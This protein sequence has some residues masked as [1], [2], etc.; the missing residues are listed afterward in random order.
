MEQQTDFKNAYSLIEAAKTIAIASH[1]RPDGDAI[2]STLALHY[3]LGFFGKTSHMYIDG[4]I[5][6]NFSY[7]E[8]TSKIRDDEWSADEIPSYDLLIIV[9]ANSADRLGRFKKL[10]E[11][12]KK[13]LVFDHHLDPNIDA[14][15]IV[16]NTSRASTGEVLFE[17]FKAFN[18][19]INK[20]MAA[21]LYTAIS[22]DTGCFVFPS[23]TAYTHK[24]AAE[25]LSIGIDFATINYYNFRMFDRS[26]LDAFVTALDSIE[27]LDEGKIS[28][29]HI[30]HKMM[31]RYNFDHD[32][33]H[34]IQRYAIDASGVVINLFFTEIDPD[35]FSVSLRSHGEVNVA[36]LAK[37]FGGGGHKN[38]AGFT[39]EGKYKV[40]LKSV[41]D[42]ARAII[43]PNRESE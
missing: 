25:L 9:D 43:P 34:R 36:E 10:V 16:M 14:D 15:T 5:S 18:I 31:S 2:G 11:T 28:L 19:P 26:K 7:M 13:I 20:S 21:A 12:S 35:V 23:T 8:G 29:V 42:E 22:T 30:N 6:Q 27:F 1:I 40:L 4:D 24:V 37:K 32:E 17:F 33:K 3:W 39:K 38:A 41:L